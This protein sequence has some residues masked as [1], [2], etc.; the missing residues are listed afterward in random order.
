MTWRIRSKCKVSL[1]T[2]ATILD[3]TRNK[4]SPFAISTKNESLIPLLQKLCPLFN[5][6]F[7]LVFSLL[8]QFSFRCFI[9]SN[10]ICSLLKGYCLYSM[11]SFN[12]ELALCSI[13]NE[14]MILAFLGP[15]QEELKNAWSPRI[16]Q[17]LKLH[18]LLLSL[19]D[20]IVQNILSFGPIH[21]YYMSTSLYGDILLV[22]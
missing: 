20:S 16:Y 2:H 9:V 1:A 5:C 15:L 10:V 7:F 21:C 22:N 11:F 19:K 8:F 12:I 6:Y 4:Q 18:D 13:I 3:S 17:S 14:G